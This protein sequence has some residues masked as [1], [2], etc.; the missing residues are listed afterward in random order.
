[1]TATKTRAAKRKADLLPAAVLKPPASVATLRGDSL[2]TLRLDGSR[3]DI[4]AADAVLTTSVERTIE[5]GST[6]T[7]DVHDRDE[8]LTSTDFLDTD[9][10]TLLDADVLLTIDGLAFALARVEDTHPAYKLIFEDYAVTLLKSA[11]GHDK[12]YRDKVTRAEFVWSL[13]R[14]L[15]LN[16]YCPELLDRLPVK[17]PQ[18][19]ETKA[20]P[21]AD[22]RPGFSP[23]AKITVKGQS[24]TAFQV[25]IIQGCLA[26]A[27]ALGASEF[28]MVCVVAAITQES[29]AGAAINVQTGNDDVGIYQQGR[30]WVSVA[31]AKDPTASTRAFLVGGPTSFKKVHG[32]IK[33]NGG[34]VNSLVK[35]VQISVGG[36]GPWAGE[37][38]RTVAAFNG[39][40]GGLSA[41]GGSAGGGSKDV[42]QRFVFRVGEDGKTESYWACM[43]RLAAEVG[44]RCFVVGNTV[45]YMSEPELIAQRPAMTIWREAPGVTKL[46][47]VWDRGHTVQEASLAVDVSRWGAQ[48]GQAVQV[49]QPGP[50]G[51]R[52]LVATTSRSLTKTSCEITLKRPMARK[53]EPAPA[54]KSVSVP[55]S[56][57]SGG[58]T[59]PGGKLRDKIVDIAKKSMTSNSGFS[60]YSLTGTPNLTTILPKS[61][62]TDCSQWV[63][64][65]YNEAGA[66]FPG[67]FTGDM[68]RRAKRTEKPKPGDVLVSASHCEL[69]IG[70]GKTIGHGSPPIDYNTVAWSIGFG[71]RFYT[72]DF[73]D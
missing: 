34:D 37:A 6:V 69:Y 60:R 46:E 67:S 18:L 8:I 29:T 47:G 52:W 53:A 63:A 62:R 25:R 39:G 35:A 7:V 17:R 5:G 50:L 56:P 33:L 22:R 49:T 54:T 48:P 9:H 3:F 57:S 41:G 36:Y 23:G 19:S 2:K 43:Q 55:G 15:G 61:G 26:E 21:T 73:L 4:Q 31:G 68:M 20:E 32:S 45:V 16:F 12:A 44:F 51:G 1:M 40:T 28:V 13:V 10:D 64:A 27:A 58:L 72:Y 14:K 65:V 11:Q 30:N 38:K 42:A 71:L 59:L 70:D 24:A 66:G